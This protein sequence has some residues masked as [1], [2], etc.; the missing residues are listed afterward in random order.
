VLNNELLIKR[1]PSYVNTTTV[2]RTTLLPHNLTHAQLPNQIWAEG[3]HVGTR[4]KAG[5]ILAIV[6]DLYFSLL[7]DR[8]VIHIRM[9][10]DLV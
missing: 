7:F 10:V 1:P 2:L 8:R 4:D 9:S 3:L 6:M 5:C